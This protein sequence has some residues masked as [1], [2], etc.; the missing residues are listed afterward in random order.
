MIQTISLKHKICH[1]SQNYTTQFS[2]QT[3]NKHTV[4]DKRMEVGRKMGLD[5][6]HPQNNVKTE[7]KLGAVEL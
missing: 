4:G 6:S 2:T 3:P 1:K 5:G 7:E